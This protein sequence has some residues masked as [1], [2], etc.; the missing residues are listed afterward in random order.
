[1][2]NIDSKQSQINEA[3]VT[4]I[5]TVKKTKIIYNSLYNKAKIY[6]IKSNFLLWFQNVTIM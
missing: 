2:W 6:N 4:V 3:A 1:M 5:F